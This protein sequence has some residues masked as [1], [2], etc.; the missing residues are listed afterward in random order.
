MEK[1]KKSNMIVN[2]NKIFMVVKQEKNGKSGDWKCFCIH[3]LSLFDDDY[4]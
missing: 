4:S 1:N 3:A 2:N